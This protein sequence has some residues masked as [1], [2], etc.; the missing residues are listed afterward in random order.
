MK[1]TKDNWQAKAACLGSD[2]EA[3]FPEK[4][5]GMVPRTV[6]ATCPVKLWCIVDGI[7]E[8]TGIWG[9][10]L[11]SERRILRQKFG[12]DSVDGVRNVAP[13]QAAG[14]AVLSGVNVFDA[15]RTHKLNVSSLISLLSDHT[16]HA[17]RMYMKK[18]N[19]RYD[20]TMASRQRKA[21]AYAY[22]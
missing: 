13:I 2:P 19:M 21:A 12:V 11:P 14:Y 15:A 22:R 3:W 5:Y 1:V 7:G 20:R 8:D 9:G 18:R 6:C 4:S 17:V 10:T 16:S